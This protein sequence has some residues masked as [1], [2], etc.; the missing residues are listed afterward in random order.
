M[1]DGGMKPDL[2]APGN[3]I[4]SL[5]VPGSTIDTQ[6]AWAAVPTS[7]YLSSAATATGTVASAYTR[8]SGTS[9]A[10]P[11]VAGAVAL[12]LQQNGSLTPNAV[13][14][15]LMSSAQLLKG[16][17]P[18]LNTTLVYDPFT[19]GAGELNIPGAVQVASLLSSS[20]GLSALPTGYSTINGT[21][22]PL[23]CRFGSS[24]A[25]VLRWQR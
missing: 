22:F 3:K 4:V 18:V 15:A 6:D 21:P 17:D 7:E 23:V 5:R 19:Q 20:K 12:M 9:M 10:A 24:G 14:G 2:L 11:A 13:K 16:F 1:Y 8:L 25:V